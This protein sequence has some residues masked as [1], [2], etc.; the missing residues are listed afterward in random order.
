MKKFEHSFDFKE[1]VIKTSVLDGLPEQLIK[2][3]QIAHILSFI[4][5]KRYSGSRFKEFTRLLYENVFETDWNHCRPYVE[6]YTK[7]EQTVRGED[8]QK[9]FLKFSEDLA[10]AITRV[11]MGMFLAAAIDMTVIDF[12]WRNLFHAA[13]GFDDMETATEILEA[14]QR[15]H[16]PQSKE[17]PNEQE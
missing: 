13:D 15:L 9:Q 5:A 3:F 7:L 8:F 2:S 1:T 14:I 10:L 4:N 11:P 6:R 17:P 16:Q 12:Y